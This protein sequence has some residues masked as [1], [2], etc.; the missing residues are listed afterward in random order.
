MDTAIEEIDFLA[1][2][3]PRVGVIE[4]LTEGP[5]ESRELRAATG[6]LFTDHESNSH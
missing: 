6:G 1:R 5:R 2:S 4:G 3:G